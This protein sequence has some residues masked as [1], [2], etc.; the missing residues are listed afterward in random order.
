MRSSNYPLIRLVWSIFFIAISG[1]SMAQEV[2]ATQGSTYSNADGSIE[3]TL[4]EIIT[5][6]ITTNDYI[7]TQGF[8][9][10]YIDVIPQD[11][12]GI[13][14]NS[15]TIDV[16][17]NPTSD[18]LTINIPNFEKEVT[19]RLFSIDGIEMTNGKFSTQTQLNIA[20]YPQGVYLLI[21]TNDENQLIETFKIQRL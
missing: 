8:N 9:Q 1:V 5:N 10:S 14:N 3:F 15:V 20:S 17:P 21:L 6:T 2:I 11:V 13:G 12:T 16:F 18:H 4:G 7:V 19:M